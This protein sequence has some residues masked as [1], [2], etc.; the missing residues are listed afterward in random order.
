MNTP[1]VI[2]IDV[3]LHRVHAW[4]SRDGRVCFNAPDFPFEALGSH[5]VILLEIASPLFYHDNPKTIYQTAKWTIYNSFMFGRLVWVLQEHLIINRLL[6]SPSNHWTLGHQED[7]RN[8]M[9]G[10]T[11]E[12]NHDIRACRAMQWFYKNAPGRW[13]P[14]EEF[15]QNL[16]DKGKP[17]KKKAKKK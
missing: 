4:S 7:I 16:N 6:V 12:D 13:V 1:A 15:I 9:A 14:Y 17:P 2:S 8:E 3:D 5:D 11:G 10:C